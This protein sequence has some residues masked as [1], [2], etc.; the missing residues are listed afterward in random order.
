MGGRSLIRA[1]IE[2]PSQR[3]GDLGR[4][5]HRR[6]ITAGRGEGARDLC[7]S[8]R[9]MEQRQLCAA[10]TRISRKAEAWFAWQ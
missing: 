3:D 6:P 10:A 7:D 9:Q 4:V 1:A 8:L 5:Q 2:V